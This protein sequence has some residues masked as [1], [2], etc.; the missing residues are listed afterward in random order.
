MSNAASWALREAYIDSCETPIE[1][2]FIDAYFPYRNREAIIMPQCRIN[3]PL[4][5]FRLDFLLSIGGLNIGIECDG[6]KYHKPAR[7]LLRDVLILGSGLVHGIMRFHGWSLTHSAE[8]CIYT[9]SRYYPELFSIEGRIAVEA[10]AN[11][12]VRELLDPPARYICCDMKKSSSARHLSP[13]F[14]DLDYYEQIKARPFIATYHSF[15]SQGSDARSLIHSF[16]AILLGTFLTFD[17]VFEAYPEL[18]SSESDYLKKLSLL[19]A[20]AQKNFLSV[21]RKTSKEYRDNC[22][23]I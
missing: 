15:A 8:D 4:S 14:E 6:M 5:R 1:K 16:Y 3:V 17:E 23:F 10:F 18:D 22:W 13:D 19:S 7:D 12:F 9:L 11:P 2:L 21:L 20:S